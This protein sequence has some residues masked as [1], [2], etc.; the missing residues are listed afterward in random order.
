[1]YNN[2]SHMSNIVIKVFNVSSNRSK[3]RGKYYFKYKEKPY[4]SY[5]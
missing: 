3:R 4:D 2:V 1:M 5:L